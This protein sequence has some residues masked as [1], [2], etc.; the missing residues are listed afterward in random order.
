LQNLNEQDRLRVLREKAR[1][2]LETFVIDM[3][4]NIYTDEYE[5]A[6]G[7]EEKEKITQACSEVSQRSSCSVLIIKN[8]KIDSIRID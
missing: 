2:A 8:S 3:Q 1:N 7:A 6:V 4:N 5:K